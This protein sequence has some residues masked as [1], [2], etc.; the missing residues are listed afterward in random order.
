MFGGLHL[1]K[2]LWTAVGEILHS[3]GWATAFTEAGIASSGRAD[4]FLK[5]FHITRTRH[6]H[7]VNAVALSKLQHL[8]F[9]GDDKDFPEWKKSMR[10]SLPT[11]M[12]WD[13]I[14]ET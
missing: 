4:S 3:S 8:A 7:Q 13:F 2:G 12:Y 14:L 6:T 5:C 1:E 9:P 10:E 11:F